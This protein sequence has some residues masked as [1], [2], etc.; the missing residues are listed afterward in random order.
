MTG[1]LARHVAALSAWQLPGGFVPFHLAKDHVGWLAPSA[2]PAA[3]AHG[4]TRTEDFVGLPVPARLATLAKAL[5]ADGAFALRKE[6]FDVRATPDG[7][8]LA[9]L[10]RGALPWFGVIGQGV[11][12]NGLVRRADGLHVWVGRRAD[13]C[14]MDPGKLDHL[15]A[16]GIGAGSDA[17][18]TVLK[19]GAEEAGLA[20]SVTAAALAAGRLS[21]VAVRPEGLR[22]DTLHCYDLILPE[23][24]TPVPADGEV[25]AFELWPAARVIETLRETDDFKFNVAVVLLDMLL[26]WEQ[27]PQDDAAEV[28]R[29]L[30]ALKGPLF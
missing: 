7:P 11:H 25:A 17:A 8:V 1:R 29:A 22:R 23:D 18:A 12:V 6:L 27:L 21:Y 3:C 5:A 10:D 30:E 24:V 26:R 2:V 4:C 16:G 28:G 20:E 9:T 19:E 15:F 14:L 13:T